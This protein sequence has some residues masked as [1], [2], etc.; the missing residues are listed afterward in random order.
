MAG[1][2][3]TTTTKKP[4]TRCVKRG[5]ALTQSG[6]GILSSFLPGPAG[7]IA[8][9]LGLGRKPRRP[10]RQAGS[11]YKEIAVDIL[12]KLVPQAQSDLIRLINKA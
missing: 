12:N 11:G 8:G 6:N 4:C 7:K 2:R 3:K 10:R 5:G 1:K 9:M